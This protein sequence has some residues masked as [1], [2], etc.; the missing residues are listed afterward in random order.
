MRS[1]FE[2]T[3]RVA[4]GVHSPVI[5]YGLEYAVARLR[6]S[7]GADDLP[8]HTHELSDRV[9][10]VLNGRGFFHWST[11]TLEN[12]SGGVVQTVAA[13]ER[14]VFVF[15]QGLLHT[16]STA[17]SPMELVSCQLPF[18]PF[19]DERQYSLPSMLWTPRSDSLSTH[20]GRADSPS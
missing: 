18:L 1:P 20:A 6:W 15:R 12:F 9:I 8:L 7:P 5:G 4:G 3:E 19:D 16:F 13:R 14:D 10:V 2:G 11:E 17:D